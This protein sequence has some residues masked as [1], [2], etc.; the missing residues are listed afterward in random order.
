MIIH[1]VASID[2]EAS[3]PSYAV[4]RLCESLIALGTDVKLAVLDWLAG[5]ASPPF[6]KR[7]RLGLGPRRLGRSPAM[8]RW[9]R[10]QI[11]GGDVE[12]LHNHGL[13]MMPNVYPGWVA[14]RFNWRARVHDT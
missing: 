6:V 7:F 10:E 14:R 11:E 4:P 3:G 9:L 5:Q 13:W 1:T 8:A 12:I 2:Q